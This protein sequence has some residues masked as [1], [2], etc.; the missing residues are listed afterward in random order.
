M[1]MV[2]FYLRDAGNQNIAI[3]DNTGLKMFKGSINLADKFIVSS[4]GSCRPQM[5]RLR[6]A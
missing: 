5:P 4:E 6:A 1:G 2:T 3:M